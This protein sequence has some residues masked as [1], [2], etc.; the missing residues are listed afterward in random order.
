MI[1]VWIFEFATVERIG[2]FACLGVA[3]ECAESK[4]A[5]AWW[6]LLCPRGIVHNNSLC[7]VVNLIKGYQHADIL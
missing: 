4:C 1:E 3:M 2:S 6:P 5:N 7:L